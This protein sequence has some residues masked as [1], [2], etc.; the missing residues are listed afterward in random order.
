VLR[1]HVFK[2]LAGILGD[3]STKQNVAMKLVA[4]RRKDDV[5]IL[6]GD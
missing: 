2:R 1:L 4:H 3:E 6:L 5:Q